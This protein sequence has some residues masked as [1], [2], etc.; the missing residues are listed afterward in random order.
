MHCKDIGA[1]SSKIT[2]SAEEAV[3]L[4]PRVKGNK[5]MLR[6]LTCLLFF[7]GG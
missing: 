4:E 2:W 3:R 6:K 5:T 1:S 7:N